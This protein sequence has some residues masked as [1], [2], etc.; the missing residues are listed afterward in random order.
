MKPAKLILL[1]FQGVETELFPV[2]KY[3]SSA[4]P[5]TAPTAVNPVITSGDAALSIS[6]PC[7]ERR[8]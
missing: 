5:T 1:R 4:R 6:P 8:T 7:I 3:G 2:G